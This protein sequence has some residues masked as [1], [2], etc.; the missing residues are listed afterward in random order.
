MHQAVAQTL[1]ER[2]VG[3]WPPELA[4]NNGWIF[5]TLKFP[6]IDCE[7]T[8]AGRTPLRLRFDCAQWD[9][10]PPS[11]QLQDS[12]GTPLKA[13]PGQP[14]SVF[15]PGPHPTNGKPFLCIAGVKEFHIHSSHLNET[16]AQF[17]NKPGFSLGDMLMKIWH[18]WLRGRG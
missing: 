9:T 13:L 3:K 5:H 16:W 14:D 18:A 11:V 2:E 4:A 15:N 10:E 6:V 17:R 7:F 12:A 1:F 8:R